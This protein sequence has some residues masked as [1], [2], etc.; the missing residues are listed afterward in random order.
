MSP[1]V[2]L[3]LLLATAS[4]CTALRS[5]TETAAN[6][7][8]RVVTMLQ[9]MVNKVEAEGKKQ[10]ELFDKFICYC[11]NADMTLGKSIGD[12]ETKIPQLE[13]D[14]KEAVAAHAQLEEDLVTHKQ[15]RVD[16]TAN[17]EKSTSMRKTDAA[18][19][20]AESAN[21]SSN[22]DAL[23][24]A[25]AAIEKGMAGS[26]LQTD[27]AMT[28]R[29]LSLSDDSVSL[30]SVD[31][32]VLSNFLSLKAGDADKEGDMGPQSGEI[33]GILKQMKDTMEKD[34]AELTAQEASA[35]TDFDGLIAA[36][37]KI[38][39]SATQAIEEKTARVGEVAVE[40]V[41][42]KHDLEDTQEAFVEDKGFLAGLGKTCD[43]KKKEWAASQ[44]M[45]TEELIALAD[46]I[47]MLND[48]DAQ[49]LFKKTL[50]SSASLIQLGVSSKEV[51]T[52]ALQALQGQKGLQISLLTLALK[53][54]KGGLDKVVTMIDDM[55]ALL[56]KEQVED[57]NKKEY[58]EIQLDQAEDSAKELKIGI[59]DS[60]K[61]IAESKEQIET[62]TAEMAAL[63]AGIADLD[64][65]VVVATQ[66]RKEE[67][68]DCTAALAADNAA[69]QLIEIAK[70]RLQKFYNPKLY[71]A[72]P[73]RE[74]TEEERITLNMGGTLA[75]TEAPGGIAGTG[76]GL[77]QAHTDDEDADAEAPPPPPAADLAA[78]PKGEESAGVMAMMDSL[79]ADLNKEMQELEFEEKDSQEDYETMMGESSAKRAEDSKAITDKEGA[80]AELEAA[81][82]VQEE[83]K[84]GQFKELMATKEYLGTL[85]KECDWLLA[86]FDKRK[87]ARTNEIDA[88]GKAKA[89]LS[90][91]DISLLQA[92][93]QKHLRRA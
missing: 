39:A 45:R 3:T 25:I 58:C 51:R 67:H 22:L 60:E 14:I 7:M 33:M 27:G 55:V 82:H 35:K 41:N 80:K 89:V 69:K 46:V 37:E 81:L 1:L 90:G 92:G 20:A 84:E 9:M 23:T 57:E 26:F 73:K 93:V 85:H 16:A 49:D 11:D 12:A 2:V 5:Q 38:I 15:D 76:V 34:L 64:K 61:A 17:I 47:K 8:R 62:Y 63:E 50:P 54:K 36:Q 91:A 13:S 42:M 31:R 53:G 52:R 70:N 24:K 10:E 88:L 59:S 32:D 19:F 56:K 68:E 79:T 43:L 75:P 29:R 40:I 71:K 72:P 78:K 87:A 48:D 86:N 77:V 83:T 44:K 30:T 28:L 66:Q 21:D 6:P 74:L 18:A 65:S 4:P